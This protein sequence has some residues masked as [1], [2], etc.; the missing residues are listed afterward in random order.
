MTHSRYAD[1][2]T[3]QQLGTAFR[4]ALQL[5]GIMHEIGSGGTPQVGDLMRDLDHEVE[6]RFPEVV[7]VRREQEIA[8]YRQSVAAV[9]D[10]LFEQRDRLLDRVEE[11]F[12]EFHIDTARDAVMEQ[13]DGPTFEEWA[14]ELTQTR[15]PQSVM[16]SL[17]RVFAQSVR[18]E[19]EARGGAK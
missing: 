16:E 10:A 6:K 3:D 1:T 7:R 15:A 19:I 12:E 8:I 4:G 2:L 18:F 14:S 13:L 17:F 9:F 5:H 11:F